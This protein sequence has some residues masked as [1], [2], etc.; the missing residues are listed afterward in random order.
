[1]D[2]DAVIVCFA[3]DDVESLGEVGE[4]VRRFNHLRENEDENC[5]RDQI[6]GYR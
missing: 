1:M 6:K 3:V 2:S 4:K 5:G